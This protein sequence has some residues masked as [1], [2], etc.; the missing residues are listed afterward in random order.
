M[1]TSSILWT[2]SQDIPSAIGQEALKGQKNEN[3]HRN[4]NRSASHQYYVSSEYH[5][6][7]E[8]GNTDTNYKSPAL[9][10]QE[11]ESIR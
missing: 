8:L 6:Y 3:F 2:E 1:P 9:K 11:D 5:F 4:S 10:G 7:S